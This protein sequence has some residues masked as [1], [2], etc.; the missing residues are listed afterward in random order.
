MVASIVMFLIVG[1]ASLFVAVQLHEM[2]AAG[3]SKDKFEA[4]VQNIESGKLQLT[5]DQW[6]EG[7]QRQHATIAADEAAAANFSN[8]MLLLALA[9]LIAIIFQIWMVLQIRKRLNGS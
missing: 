5:T 6:L 3:E 4:F 7:L 9:S 1:V 2:A 8:M